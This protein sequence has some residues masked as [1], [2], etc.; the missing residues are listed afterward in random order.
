VEDFS[1]SMT[2]LTITSTLAKGSSSVLGKQLCPSQVGKL[3]PVLSCGITSKTFRTPKPKPPPFPYKEKKY[4][5]WRSLL[6][7]KTTDRFD[8]NSKIIVVDGPVAAGKSAFAKELAEDLDMLHIPEANMDM[9][10][11]NDYGY[12]MRELDPRMPPSMRSFDEKNFCQDP[13]HVNVAAFQIWMYRLRFSLYVD[14]LA[15]V[16][17]T[18]Q[19]VVIERSPWSDQVFMEAMALNKFISKGARRA[20][21]EVRK[22]TLPHLMRPH[23]VIY[24]DI[25]V[26]V[27][28]QK[29]TKRALPHE[30]NSKALTK[31]FLEDMENIYKRTYLREMSDHSE[32]LIYDWSEPGDTEVIVEDIERIDFDCYTKHDKK[33]S[34]WRKAK[35][36]IWAECRMEYADNKAGLMTLFNVPVF[37]VP[38]LVAKADEVEQWSKIWH[39]APGMEYE[40]G[41][42]PLKGD[43]D[44]LFKTAAKKYIPY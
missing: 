17:S 28:Q 15:H 29:I 25:P 30:A 13:T 18:G 4:T 34:D 11:I 6:F 41:F 3:F 27:V 39:S 21:L 10:Y 32:L 40:T 2:L 14:A 31:K 43:S 20:Y 42:N 35:E 37:D 23:L 8:E 7:D 12:N 44:L 26:P 33:L 16:L 1:K 24:L 19:G 36:N 38:E 9:R 5:L 22:N